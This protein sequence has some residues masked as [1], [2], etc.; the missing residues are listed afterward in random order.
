MHTNVAFKN[1]NQTE[2]FIT[3]LTFT[4][5]NAKQLIDK[6][7]A[8]YPLKAIQVKNSYAPDISQRLFFGLFIY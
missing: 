4:M 8:D 1:K 3:S 5:T 2:L 7:I 6:L